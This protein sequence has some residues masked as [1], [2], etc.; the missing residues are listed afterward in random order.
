MSVYG[1]E[2]DTPY[3]H[4]IIAGMQLSKQ[5]LAV[6]RPATDSLKMCS[7]FHAL[8]F[9][10]DQRYAQRRESIFTPQMDVAYRPLVDL[11]AELHA[12]LM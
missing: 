1:A 11:H 12:N 2:K 5:K 7:A 9:L 6:Y 8:L 3:F 10:H 4:S